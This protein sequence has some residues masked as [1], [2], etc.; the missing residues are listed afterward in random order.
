MDNPQIVIKQL[1][2]L[3]AELQNA[4]K[5]LRKIADDKALSEMEYRKALAVKILL[6]KSDNLPATLIMDLARGSDEVSLLK[7]ERDKQEG[8]YE[9]VK[10]NINSLNKRISVGQS[11]LS[12]L[13][14]EYKASNQLYGG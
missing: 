13:T 6:L 2:S 12:N 8:L 4:N 5:E 11:I 14:S 3:G 10:Y 9:A 1:Q 7:L